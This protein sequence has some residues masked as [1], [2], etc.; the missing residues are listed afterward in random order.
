MIYTQRAYI[1]HTQRLPSAYPARISSYT[2]TL[3]NVYSHIVDLT[4]CQMYCWQFCRE[5]W[6]SSCIM[7]RRPRSKYSL[8]GRRQAE[9]F[10]SPGSRKFLTPGA[11]NG[12]RFWF[13][14]CNGASN[15]A[16]YIP[17]GAE[18]FL[19]LASNIASNLVF[20][21]ATLEGIFDFCGRIFDPKL[22]A[23]L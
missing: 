9:N 12:L 23:I 4:L 5:Y 18:N 19:G 20:R 14:D 13:P 16:C 11:S 10:A 2:S 1:A 8:P 21:A 3:P 7:K 22:H 6:H 17:G 15:I